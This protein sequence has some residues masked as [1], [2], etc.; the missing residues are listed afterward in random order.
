MQKA[1][2]DVHAEEYSERDHREY[3]EGCCDADDRMILDVWQ[4]SLLKEDFR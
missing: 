1:F 4:E 2:H 3:E